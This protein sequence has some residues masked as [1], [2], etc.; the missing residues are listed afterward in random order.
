MSD[1]II[2]KAGREKSLHRRHPWIFSGAIAKVQGKPQLG[3]S[4]DVFSEK[5]EWLAVAAYSPHSQIR[6]RVWSFTP[7]QTIDLAFFIERIRAAQ[8]FRDTHICPITNA[9]RVVAGESDGLPGITI[10]RYDNV[11]VCQLL[12]AGAA[13]WEETI[14][15]A[16]EVVFPGAV[17]YERSDVD[18]RSKEGLKKAQGLRRGHLDDTNILIH[19][20]GVQLTV[21]IKSGHKTG[22]YLDQ[23]DARL[24]IQR[25]AQNKSVLNCFSY[26]GGFGLYAA[27][28][29]AKRVVNVDMSQNALHGARQNEGLNQ[30]TNGV[31]EYIQAD[32]FTQLR[33]FRETNETFDVIVLDPPKFVDS[34]ASLMRACRGYKDINRLAAS[35]LNPN[36]ILMT[37]SCSGLL[38]AELFQKVVADASLDAQVDLKIIDRTQQDAD[39]PV[40]VH[41]PEGWYLKGLILQRGSE[42]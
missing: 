30:L 14:Y 16:L 7:G 11:L 25:Y 35:L 28:A 5:G 6:A 24:R 36:G 2:I 22:Y 20:H 4:V 23:R 29:G 3:S 40:H 32:V 26:T 19:E 13:Y 33:Q 31:I 12:S 39:H 18:V 15:N 1:R 34:K 9:Y 42:T 41:Y 38:S 21:D 17:I 10:D 8:L 27:M 37:F